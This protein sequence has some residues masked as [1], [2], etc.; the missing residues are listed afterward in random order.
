MFEDNVTGANPRRTCPFQWT[1]GGMRHECGNGW[2]HYDSHRCFVHN[3][4]VA[5]VLNDLAESQ[6]RA[7]H[8]P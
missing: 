6:G 4:G 5:R 2:G 1:H 7:S 8:T 3:C